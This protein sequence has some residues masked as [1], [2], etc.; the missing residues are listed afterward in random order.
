MDIK[1]IKA[2]C[3]WNPRNNQAV[4]FLDDS[5]LVLRFAV[6]SARTPL[7]SVD[8]IMSESRA[9]PHLLE[10]DNDGIQFRWTHEGNWYT[11]ELSG[12]TQDA[13][14]CM[15]MLESIRLQVTG[16]QG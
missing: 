16:D 7:E 12:F 9:L 11:D 5:Y 10:P 4:A 8:E 1:P 15:A 14:H 6:R 13:D 3:Y 2:T